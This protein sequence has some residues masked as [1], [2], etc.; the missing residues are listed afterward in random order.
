MRAEAAGFARLWV[1]DTP[2]GDALAGLAAAAERTSSIGLATGVVP[3]DRVP[4]R[5]LAERATQ[6][7]GVSGRLTVGIGS[8]R[9][10]EG[11]PRRSAS[12]A[13]PGCPC[14]SARWDHGCGGSP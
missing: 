3:I 1:N 6:I 5:G 4:A 10:R 11:A 7:A 14:S 8:G 13:K 2:G 9:L 12:C